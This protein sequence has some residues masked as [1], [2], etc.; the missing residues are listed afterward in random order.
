MRRV[1]LI[2]TDTGAP[3]GKETG[4]QVTHYIEPGGAFER[5][6]A[7]LMAE[8]FVLPYVELWGEAD[9]KTRKKKA[10][11]KSK[12]TCETCGANAWAKPESLLI[13]G[14]CFDADEGGEPV[15]MKMEAPE[16]EGDD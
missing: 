3:G 15:T 8:G 14:A 6:C 10:A 13:C 9:G 16:G 4:Q 5:A 7:A 2:P 1:G 11:S 12:Y